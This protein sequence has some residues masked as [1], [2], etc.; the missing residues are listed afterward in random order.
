MGSVNCN[1]SF[2]QLKNVPRIEKIISKIENNFLRTYLNL[3]K[4]KKLLK[5]TIIVK[6]NFLFEF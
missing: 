6:Q 5:N 4:A 1:V 3:L 2:V